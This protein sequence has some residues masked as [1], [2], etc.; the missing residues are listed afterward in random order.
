MCNSM[1]RQGELMTLEAQVLICWVTS[2]TTSKPTEVSMN[3]GF[4][5]QLCVK[6]GYSNPSTGYIQ[7]SLDTMQLQN[8]NHKSLLESVNKTSIHM[9][10]RYGGLPVACGI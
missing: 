10:N 6:K 4:K 3:N 8:S 7:K 9:R 5:T 1:N 2:Y